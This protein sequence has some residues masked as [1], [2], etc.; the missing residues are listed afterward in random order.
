MMEFFGK[1]FFFSACVLVPTLVLMWFVSYASRKK[2]DND[3]PEE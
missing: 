1:I 3:T 2:Q